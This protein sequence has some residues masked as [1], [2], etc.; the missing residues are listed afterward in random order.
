MEPGQLDA[1]FEAIVSRAGQIDVLVNNGHEHCGNDWTDISGKQFNRVLANAT[2][3]FLLA[4]HLHRHAR[5]RGAPASVIMLGSMYGQV[6]SYPDAYQGISPAS[7]VAYHTLKG[8]IL[9]LTRHLAVYWADDGVRVN[10]LSPGPFPADSVAR[11]LVSN[12]E[13][14]SPM[15]RMG[16]PDELKGAVVFLA[17]DASSYMTGQN[18]IIDGGWTAW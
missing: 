16:R 5:D 7:S 18:L 12:L 3:Y 14:H 6:A 2:G 15:R 9:H 4:R 8:G 10:S 11:N 13:E 17:S 1:Q